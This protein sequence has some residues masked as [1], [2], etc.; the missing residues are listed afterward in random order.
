MPGHVI[1][2]EAKNPP[3]LLGNSQS[4]KHSQKVARSA[5]RQ[6]H[7]KKFGWLRSDFKRIAPFEVAIEVL[8]TI[9][10]HQQPAMPVIAH[11]DCVPGLFVPHIQHFVAD[12]ASAHACRHRA[13][14]PFIHEG[15]EIF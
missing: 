15:M 5:S 8:L 1:L 2:S 12:E 13:L 4:Y 6:S 9:E 10:M 3:A 11:K 14:E 7:I